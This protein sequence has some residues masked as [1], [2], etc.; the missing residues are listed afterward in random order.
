MRGIRVSIQFTISAAQ[1][2][3]VVTAQEPAKLPETLLGCSSLAAQ[4]EF[5]PGFSLLL[6]ARGLRR[7]TGPNQRRVLTSGAKSLLS[8]GIHR[9]AIVVASDRTFNVAKTAS[10]LAHDAGLEMA[11]F[12]SMLAALY[13]IDFPRAHALA[14][15]IGDVP[16]A[17]LADI[18]S[19]EELEELARMRRA[20]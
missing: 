15:A 5:V 19:S 12:R 7:F 18:S 16:A 13:W 8:A 10:E 9:V 2:L 6:D 3:V 11:V 20:G 14:G 4:A 17:V 1:Q